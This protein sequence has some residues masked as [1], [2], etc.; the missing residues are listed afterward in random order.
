MEKYLTFGEF[1]DII[2]E[3]PIDTTWHMKCECHDE[4]R[5]IAFA[6]HYYEAENGGF[7]DYVVYSYPMTLDA[8]LIQEAEDGW[9]G[10]ILEVWNDILNCEYKPLKPIQS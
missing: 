9:D 10:N 5:T 7:Y 4:T 3:L 2:V 6:K 1:R 8:G